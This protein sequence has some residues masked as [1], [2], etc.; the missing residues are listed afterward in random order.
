MVARAVTAQR[1]VV[2]YLR[3]LELLGENFGQILEVPILG[4]VSNRRRYRFRRRCRYRSR[5]YRIVS[6]IRVA[7][8][9]WSDGKLGASRMLA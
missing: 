6:S 4:I 1:A 5:A 2:D 3:Y 7:S 9:N 8:G